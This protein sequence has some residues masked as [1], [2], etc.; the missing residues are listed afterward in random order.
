LS[1]DKLYPFRRSIWF[2][3]P[4]ALAVALGAACKQ[5]PA[6]DQTSEPGS[7]GVKEQDMVTTL[8]DQAA[9]MS[10]EEYNPARIVHAVN[11]LQPLGKDMA[12]ERIASCLSS[13]DKATDA[14]GLF[15]VLRAL[16]D[17]PAGQVFPPVRIGQPSIPPP[18]DPGKLPRFPIMMVQDI[19]FL[20]VSGYDLG[21]MPEP[22][23][24]H[25]TYFRDH[26]VLRDKLLSLPGSVAGLEQEI[27]RQWRVAYGDTYAEE[28][29][30]AMRPQIA[31]IGG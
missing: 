22:V 8:L 5:A 12:L 11:A 25:V 31:R 7:N 27:L 28:A 29:L 6:V 20:V 19:P 14:Q 21:G 30:R 15:W 16:F 17:V 2:V 1:K 13:H 9:T 18:A 3:V 4:V 23:D 24:A 10:I 26:G